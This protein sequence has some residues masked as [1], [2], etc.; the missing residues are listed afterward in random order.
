MKDLKHS[1]HYG[2]DVTK[3][4]W[5]SCCKEIISK[6]I[7]IIYFVFVETTENCGRYIAS[8]WRDVLTL[9]KSKNWIIGSTVRTP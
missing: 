1:I 2:H 9:I 5:E 8:C 3:A 4:K 6:A 7:N